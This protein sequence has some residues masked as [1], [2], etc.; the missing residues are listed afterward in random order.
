MQGGHRRCGA[1]PRR[2]RRQHRARRRGRRQ[3][4]G[5]LACRAS[6]RDERSAAGPSGRPAGWWSGQRRRRWPM[7]ARACAA[8][9]VSSLPEMVM[10][11]QSSESAHTRWTRRRQVSLTTACAARWGHIEEILVACVARAYS[12][13]A[14]ASAQGAQERASRA[15]RGAQCGRRGAATAGRRA[16]PCVGPQRARR[17]ARQRRG[18]ADGRRGRQGGAAALRG[19]AAHA[20]ALQRRGDAGAPAPKRL[21]GSP[22]GRA[23]SR[24][25]VACPARQRS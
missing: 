20:L 1:G 12:V 22:A 21:R 9:R 4:G 10:G 11:M 23:A 19:A 3:R 7:Q 6:C 15:R 5:A 24:L 2:A 18:P 8:A 13:R 14:P 25:G 16:E 17:P